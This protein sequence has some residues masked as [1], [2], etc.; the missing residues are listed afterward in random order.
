[1]EMSEEKHRQCTRKSRVN[2]NN[3]VWVVNKHSTG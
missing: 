2:K 1:M 3:K